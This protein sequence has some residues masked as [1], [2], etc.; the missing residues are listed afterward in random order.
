MMQ[1]CS[2]DLKH[3]R[4]ASYEGSFGDR[5]MTLTFVTS[6]SYFYGWIEAGC[7]STATFKS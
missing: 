7:L 4:I 5:R 1:C 6:G 2:E 3:L